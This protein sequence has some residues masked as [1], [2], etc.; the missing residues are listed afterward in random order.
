MPDQVSF[1]AQLR[2]LE[3]RGALISSILAGRCGQDPY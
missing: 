2:W 1:A 3:R